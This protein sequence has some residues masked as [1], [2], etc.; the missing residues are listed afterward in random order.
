MSI[1]GVCEQGARRLRA[2]LLPFVSAS[3]AVCECLACLAASGVGRSSNLQP[4]LVVVRLTCSAGEEENE[5]RRE[6]DVLVALE[7]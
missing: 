3:L 2:C 5:G 4:C 1:Y 6:R 7:S